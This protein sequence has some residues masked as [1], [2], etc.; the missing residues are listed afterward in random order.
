MSL[1][2]LHSVQASILADLR[3]TETARF[4]T[5]MHSTDLQS[6]S[7][8]FHLRKLVTLGYVEK[9]E[10]GSY[11][12]TVKGKEFA[13]S[14]N[15]GESGEQKQP[16]LSVLVIVRE[17][18][19]GGLVRYLFQ[20]RLRNP[21]FGF[22]S[23]IGGPVK[24]GEDIISTAQRELLKQTGLS[25][26]FVVRSFYRKRDYE[27]ASDTLLEDKLFC[28]VEATKLEGALSNSWPS[29]HNAWKTIDEF[30]AQPKYFTS[31]VEMLKMGTSYES[32]DAHYNARDY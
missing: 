32:Q 17:S 23:C 25:A 1:Q 19:S 26:E 22:W 6:D 3:H 9:L 15:G 24:W 12:L 20:K 7:F 31:I 18:S 27:T 28:I 21:Y 30:K 29:G 11:R 14:V 2:Q 13:N 16:K 5:L 8:K 10:S 4:S